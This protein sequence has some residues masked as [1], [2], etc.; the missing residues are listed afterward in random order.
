MRLD[1]LVVGTLERD[2]GRWPLLVRAGENAEQAYST[3]VEWLERRST[4]C[5]CCGEPRAKR[6]IAKHNFTQIF[7]T[8]FEKDETS[9]KALERHLDEIETALRDGR[10]H[11]DISNSHPVG[12]MGG[13][14]DLLGRWPHRDDF[15]ALKILRKPFLLVNTHDSYSAPL[16]NPRHEWIS[17]VSLIAQRVGD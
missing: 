11:L 6:M 14:L 8:K 12:Y 13:V 5:P 1:K 9:A 4:P 16:D 3:R 15:L 7:R 2:P 17:E 10:R